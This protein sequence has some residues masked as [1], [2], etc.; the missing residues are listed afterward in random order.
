MKQWSKIIAPVVFSCC[1]AGCATSNT[2]KSEQHQ[3]DAIRQL[4]EAYLA[5]Q[6]YT[7]ALSELLKAEKLNHKDHLLHQDLGIAYMA[8]GELELAVS[9]FKTALTIKPDFAS[10]RNN[11]GAVYLAMKDWDAAIESFKLLTKDLLYAT[12]HYPLANLGKAYYEKKEF[13]EA[14]KYYQEAL[15]MEPGFVNALY[16]LG[17]TYLSTGNVQKA[18]EYF[19]RSVEAAPLLPEAQFDL[20]NAQRLLGNIE[21]ARQGY[22]RVIELSPNSDLAR[23]AKQVLFDLK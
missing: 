9:Q 14:E 20:A 13:A 1:L 3:A 11:L 16:G 18:A 2:I 10:A 8:K 6:N 5:E 19:Q 23:E 15:K 12:P 22:A 17:R 4:G 21:K 7:M